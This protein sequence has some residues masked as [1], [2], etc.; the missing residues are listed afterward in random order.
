MYIYDINMRFFL[1][2][3]SVKNTDTTHFIQRVVDQVLGC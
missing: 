1:T 3:I 2:I